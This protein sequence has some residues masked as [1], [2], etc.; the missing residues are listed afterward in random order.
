MYKI[1][2]LKRNN[3]SKL[4]IAVGF[5]LAIFTLV[6]LA[7]VFNLVNFSNLFS[8]KK[9]DE[10][11]S[12]INY[13]PPTKEEVTEAQNHK[14]NISKDGVEQPVQ[15]PVVLTNGKTKVTPVLSS[16]NYTNP[17]LEASGFVPAVI[18]SGG[19]CTL[20]A[21]KDGVTQSASISGTQNAQ[22]V[23]CGLMKIN[24]DKLSTGIWKV[25]ISYSSTSYEGVSDPQTQEVL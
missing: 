18:E 7:G 10:P 4:K 13:N 23:S 19:T 25:T 11:T 5:I 16:W 21:I 8:T 20:T 15:E 24:R 2:N 17:N 14:N 12:A 3:R 6:L 9:S 1:K 22:N